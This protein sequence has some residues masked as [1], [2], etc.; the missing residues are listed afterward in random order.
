MSTDRAPKPGALL[1]RARREVLVN[2][3]AMGTMLQ[4]AGL[5]PGA[6]PEEWNVTHPEKVQAIHAAYFEAGSNMVQTNSFGGSRPKL[7]LYGY[8]DRVRELNRRAVELAREAAPPGGLVAFVV[9]PSGKMVA[10]LGD[11]TYEML[12]DVFTEQTLAAL[13]GGPDAIFIETMSD[14][15]EARAG[16][17]AAKAV[18]SLPVIATMTFNQGPQGFRTM[19]GTDPRAAAHAMADAGAD[20]IGTNCGSVT[21]RDMAAIITSM[22]EE[23][24]GALYLAQANAGTPR[25]EGGRT[26][27][28]LAPEEM[29]AEVPTLLDA[30]ANIVGGCCG[31]TPE[32]IRL[33]AACVA[34]HS[35]RSRQPD[36]TP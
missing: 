28:D 20:I 35:S 3:G 31:T 1:E 24:D 4:A 9:G 5:P 11:A 10:P 32:H 21:V 13:E 29:A 36:S 22:R 12:V 15:A 7:A 34:L 16:I 30:G 33:I 17:E 25:L 8:Q 2:D 14:P 26:I 19:M 6:C 27:Y 23:R 18:C